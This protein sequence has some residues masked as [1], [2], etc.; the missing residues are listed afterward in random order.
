[1]KHGFKERL[2]FLRIEKDVLQKDIAAVLGTTDN[3]VGNY[4]RGTRMPDPDTLKK[5]ADYFDVSIDYLLGHSDIRKPEKS[6]LET[7]A[8]HNLDEEWPADVKIMMRDAKK[9]TDR[10]KEIVKRLI[11][12][13][14]NED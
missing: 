5:L 12:D 2:K 3:A 13:L 1:M 6:N 11:K 4:E 8:Y 7:K 10:Q 14:I 9:L